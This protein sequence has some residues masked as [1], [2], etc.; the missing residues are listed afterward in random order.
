MS[1]RVLQA[2]APGAIEEAAG[3]IRA[4][5]L[6]AIATETVY[7]L[8]ANALDPFAVARVFEAKGRPSFDPLIIHVADAAMAREWVVDSEDALAFAA[9]FWPGPLTMVLPRVARLPDLV[10][11]GLPT[12]GV[13]VPDHAATRAL[14]RAAGVPIAAPS[15]NRFGAVSPTTAAHVLESLGDAVDVILDGGPAA[16]GLEST[17]V[18][19]ESGEPVILRHGGLARETLEAH[20]GRALPTR[21]FASGLPE[22]PGQLKRHYATQTPMRVVDAPEPTSDRALLVLCGPAPRGA[23]AYTQVVELS[24]AGDLRE[25]A[26]RLFATM[27]SLDAAGLRGIDAL[28]CTRTGLGAAIMDRVERACVRD[29]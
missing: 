22:A 5:K 11:S 3:A 14:I 19:W 10:T 13:R 15:A 27:R 12:V 4:G 7:G 16:V 17:I 25:A 6:V 24:P 26:C 2:D 1:A 18:A 28:A 23:G 21:L 9:R 29:E 8:G 20:L